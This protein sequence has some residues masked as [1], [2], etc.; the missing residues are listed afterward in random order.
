M[1][2]GPQVIEV[3]AAVSAHNSAAVW[4]LRCEVREAMIAWLQSEHPGAL[5]RRRAEVLAGADAAA[6]PGGLA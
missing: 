1:D 2:T 5:P 3:R 6:A 4:A